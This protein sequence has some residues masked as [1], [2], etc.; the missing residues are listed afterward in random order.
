MDDPNKRNNASIRSNFIS[1]ADIDLF[2][3]KYNHKNNYDDGKTKLHVGDSIQ[4]IDGIYN[5]I[6][7]IAGFDCEHNRTAA[8]GTVYDNGY[9]IALIPYFPYLP[10]DVWNSTTTISGGYKGSTA[11]T[12]ILPTIATNLKNTTLGSHLVNRNVL[13]S[14]SVESNYVSTAMTW[15]TAEATLMS[16]GQLTGAFGL[17]SGFYDDGEANYK[18]PLF[19]YTTYNHLRVAFW[20]RGTGGGSGKVHIVDEDGYNDQRSVTNSY[21]YRPLIYIR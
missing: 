19:N 15:T 14:S 20:L 12:S 17:N 10:Q 16:M 8:N 4:L 3:S 7:Q 18:L 5:T 13:L 21:Y 2:L 11:N 1:I 6:W 9:G